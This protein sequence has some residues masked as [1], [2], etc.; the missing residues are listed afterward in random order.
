MIIDSNLQVS[1]AQAITVTAASTSYIDQ[2]AAGDAYDSLWFVVRSKAAFTSGTSVTIALQCDD[3][4][5]FTTPKT[6]YTAAAI[7]TAAL[8]AN[9]YQVK[10]KVPPGAERYLRAYYTVSGTYDGGTIDA[11]FTPDVRIS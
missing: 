4:T 9:T 11:F 5:S 10:V 1:D 8:T 7:L 3:N 2:L 6:L